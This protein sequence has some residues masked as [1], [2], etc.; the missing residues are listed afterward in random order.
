MGVLSSKTTMLAIAHALEDHAVVPKAWPYPMEGPDVGHA[1]VGYPR[2]FTLGSAGAFQ[3]THD[4][5]TFTVLIVAGIAD[6]EETMDVVDQL[7]G[8]G[9]GAVREAIEADLADVVAFVNV[10]RGSVERL[11]LGGVPHAAV[12]YDVEVTA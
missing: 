5:A 9:A 12:R 7:L 2:E 10:S 4:K 11:L 6:A 8:D 1:V 3:R